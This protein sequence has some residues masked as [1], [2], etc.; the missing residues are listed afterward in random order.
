MVRRSGA[1]AGDRVVV[2]GTIGDAA[3][4]LKLRTDRGA[5]KRWKLDAGMRRHLAS[6]YL[7]PRPRSAVAEAVR[8]YA[9]ASMDVSDGLAG[10]LGKL[11]RASGAGATVEILRRVP[12]SKAARTAV[13][14]DPAAIHTV[15]TGGDDFEVIATVPPRALAAFRA[16]ARRAGVA[17]R[18]I[19]VVTAERAHASSTRQAASSASGARLSAI[20]ASGC[21]RYSGVTTETLDGGSRGR[22]CT[23]LPRL[24]PPSRCH[25]VTELVRTSAAYPTSTTCA[26]AQ[27]RDCRASRYEYD[28]DGRGRP[29]TGIRHNWSALDAQIEMIPRYGVMPSLPPVNCELFDRNY[30]AP[31]GVAPIDRPSRGVATTPTSCSPRRARAECPTP[32]RRGRHATIE[33]IA[34]IAPTCC[35]CRSTGFPR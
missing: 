7:L 27:S 2:T 34:Q 19:G 14:A 25:P 31:I 29:D 8:R 15:L 16:M 10:D 13:N 3:L 21:P 12:L 5:P 35:R 28:D 33:E 26:A 6:R 30:T 1:R 4:G 24:R 17:T 23:T 11:L 32:A 18:E 22:P 9:N 20:S